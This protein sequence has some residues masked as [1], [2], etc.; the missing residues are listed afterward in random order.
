[1][2]VNANK[3]PAQDA[4][5]VDAAKLAAEAHACV[6]KVHPAHG[7]RRNAGELYRKFAACKG[8]VV[9]AML[10]REEQSRSVLSAF[11]RETNRLPALGREVWKAACSSYLPQTG[12]RERQ[13]WQ[14]K[15]CSRNQRSL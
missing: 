6:G 11:G 14:P 1:M 9:A 7:P 10:G 12:T 5:R 3:S 4:A 13:G 15:S 8:L 2:S